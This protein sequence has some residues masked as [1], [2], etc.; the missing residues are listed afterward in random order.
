LSYFR[1]IRLI[2]YRNFKDYSLEFTKNCNVL[3]GTNGSGKTNI[4][5]ALSLFTKGRGIRKDQIKNFIKKNENNFINFSNFKQFDDS[6]ELKVNSEKKNNKII[7]KIFLNNDSSKKTIDHLYSLFSFLVF[8]P[9]TERLF[10]SSPSFRRNFIDGFIFSKDNAY[11]IL[12]NKYKK[13]IIER[14]KILNLNDYETSWLDKLEENISNL[15]L[16]IYKAR[17]LQIFSIQS[18]LSLLNEQQKLSF[19]KLII[20][21]ND[22]FFNDGINIELYIKELKKYREIDKIT[23]GAHIGPH[24]SDYIFQLDENILV[25]QLSTGQQKTIILL[26]YLAQS[27]YLVNE[28]NLK[29]ILLMD[30]ICSHLDD[31]NRKLLLKIT[32][33]FDLQIFMTGTDKNLFSFLSTNTNFCNITE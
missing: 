22:R 21:I 24:K 15:G 8:L 5:E 11:N 9:E 10:L 30:E 28:C 29:P 20:K 23:G 4:L 2:N 26:L 19:N 13:N 32:E 1:D 17:K 12:I 16:E 3:F 25:S 33:H 6:I 7:K 31:I 18:H 14:S 27:N